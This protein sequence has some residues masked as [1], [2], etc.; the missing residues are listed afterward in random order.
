MQNRG[1]KLKRK[2]NCPQTEFLSQIW[3]KSGKIYAKIKKKQKKEAKMG[4]KISKKF[5]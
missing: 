4:Q 1:K 2:K 3:G 5:I